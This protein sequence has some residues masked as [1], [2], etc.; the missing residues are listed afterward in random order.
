MARTAGLL[1]DPKFTPAVSSTPVNRNRHRSV[2]G[3]RGPQSQSNSCD[4][5]GTPK[6]NRRA[7]TSF[8]VR[9]LGRKRRQT[10]TV[11]VMDK[12]QKTTSGSVVPDDS[13]SRHPDDH[14]LFEKMTSYMDKKFLA[15]DTKV[16]AVSAKLDSVSS[17]VS[18]LS[19]KVDSHAAD[20]SKLQAEVLSL[21]AAPI[22]GVR[23]QVQKVISDMG[24]AAPGGANREEIQ[25]MNNEIQKLKVIHE[26]KS[27]RSGSQ[28]ASEDE[29]RYWL[30]RRTVRIWPVNGTNS[31]ELWEATGNFFYGVLKIPEGILEEKAV[32]HIRRICP[33][34]RKNKQRVHNEVLVRLR[35]VETR[36]MIQSYAPNLADTRGRAGLRLDVPC[37]MTGA[38]KCLERYGHVIKKRHGQSLKWHVNFDDMNLSLYLSIKLPGASNWE[39]LDLETA[40]EGLKEMDREGLHLFRER[41]GS[42][43]SSGSDSD[44][45][46]SVT[47]V[48]MIEESSLPRS[49]TL[50]KYRKKPTWGEGR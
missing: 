13:G 49:A 12:R 19:T 26:V 29:S 11:E 3:T 28:V 9:T 18:L 10:I 37:H 40:K 15:S 38:F 21:K 5:V 7:S 44:R 16:E 32:E 24:P 35:D 33:V 47:E 46:P 20:I 42:Q 48:E 6:R 41:L 22:D 31:K 2:D 34:N 39:K 36:D 25:R 8:P 30:S 14:S 17:T 50:E 43:L 23:R 45:T 4:R 27:S 1:R